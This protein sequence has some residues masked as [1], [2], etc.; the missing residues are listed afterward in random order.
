MNLEKLVFLR[1]EL[2]DALDTITIRLEIEKNTQRLTNLT[3]D[4]DQ[5]FQ[6]QIFSV[7]DNHK[8][9]NLQLEK[10]LSDIES[11]I[12]C[13]QD[14]INQISVNFF[15]EN[16][17]AECFVK[18]MEDIDKSRN[19]VLLEDFELNL[20]QR[21]NLHSNWQF[22]ALEIGC[23]HGEWTKHLV[24]SDPLYISDLYEDFLHSSV[25]QFP[26]IYQGRIRKYLITDFCKI[27]NLPINQ[28]GLIFS[29]NFFNYLSLD[30]IKQLLIQSMGWLRPGG[31]I[32]FTYNNADLPAA[33][34]YA[35]CYF[36][37][38]VPKSILLPMAES[39]GF[40]INF[41][42]D[43]NP[44]HSFVE[45]IK[46]GQLSSIKLSQTMGEIKPKNLT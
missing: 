23:R 1:N 43:T 22:P 34:A 4:A 41:T 17:Q 12:Q 18:D 40:R 30:S 32:I 35:E 21:I 3:I 24:A 11:L 28:F 15:A 19:L 29:Y 31:K 6:D 14:K 37:T 36:M 45:L 27:S 16:Y 42:Y 20:K 39:L 46:P 38:Y 10:N 2:R 33:A 9:I 25:K 5:E 44:A 26:D 8:T 13:V 7:I